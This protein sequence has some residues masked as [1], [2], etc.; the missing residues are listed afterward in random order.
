[1]KLNTINIL[2]YYFSWP[3]FVPGIDYRI[4]VRLMYKFDGVFV[5]IKPKFWLPV[6]QSQLKF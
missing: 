1:M 6:N 4:L 3:L 5:L 2:L